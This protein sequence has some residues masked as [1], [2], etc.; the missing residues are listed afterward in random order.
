[1]S[2]SGLYLSIV[3]SFIFFGVFGEPD[4]LIVKR[5]E[6]SVAKVWLNKSLKDV[7][8]G[9]M[10]AIDDFKGKVVLVSNFAIIH[11]AS[12]KQQD[13]M[14]ELFDSG[15][16]SFVPVSFN[17]S[18]RNDNDTDIVEYAKE[19]GFNWNITT[20]DLDIFITFIEQFGSASVNTS[21]A[22]VILVCEDQSAMLLKPGVRLVSY[23]KKAIEQNCGIN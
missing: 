9:E 23:L 7:V 14:K 8:T 12:K 18:M 1:L 3:I 17:L 5:I 19:Y 6:P 11:S 20:P 2:V 21:M 10:F 13:Q 15:D 16:A 22:P 4:S